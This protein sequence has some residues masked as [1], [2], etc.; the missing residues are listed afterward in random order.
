ML[1]I[2]MLDKLLAQWETHCGLRTPP[3]EPI[4]LWQ[5]AGRSVW[6]SGWGPVIPYGSVD[7]GN[8]HQ[9][10]GYKRLK[11]DPDA[12]RAIPEAKDWPELEGFLISVNGDGSPIESVGCEKGFFRVE[13]AGD[14]V[15]KL[16]SYVEV[17]F[18][19]VALNERPENLL[20][21]ASDLL[22][23]V[24]G[25]EKWWG[26]VEIVLEIF[27]GIPGTTRQPWGLM[28]RVTNHGRNEKEARKFWGVTLKR[29]GDAVSKMPKDFQL[30]ATNI[31]AGGS[32]EDGGE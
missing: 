21:L 4:A 19:E 11:G 10:Y 6:I 3:A 30:R 5:E 2:T 31:E 24:E 23:A 12:V 27:K 28:I 20:L 8:G 22:K 26:E 15:V 29:L 32:A 9:N 7:H 25:C 16:G 14:A 1:K 18:T 13:N 17:L